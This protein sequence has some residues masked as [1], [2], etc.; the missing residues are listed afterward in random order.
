MEFGQD[1]LAFTFIDYIKWE[2]EL[3]KILKVFEELNNIVDLPNIN[4]IVL[5]YVDIFPIL[6]EGFIYNKYF[7]TKV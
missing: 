7:T 5:T 1:Y 4:K 3:P 6:K 2:K